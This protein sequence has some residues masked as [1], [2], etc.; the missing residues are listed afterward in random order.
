MEKRDIG[1]RKVEGY[2]LQK[3]VREADNGGD[4]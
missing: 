1:T 2:N 3:I 4:T